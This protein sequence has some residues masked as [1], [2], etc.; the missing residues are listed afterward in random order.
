VGKSGA[1]R[2]A[3]RSADAAALRDELDAARASIAA[4]ADAH[5][6][7]LTRLQGEV[8]TLKQALVEV[9]E[10]VSWRLTR[11]LRSVRSR[12]GRPR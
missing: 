4:A 9:Q 11:P 5:Q 10:S 7:E 6:A 8:E 12:L 3:D 1:A 2:S